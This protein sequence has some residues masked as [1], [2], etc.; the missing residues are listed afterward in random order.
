MGTSGGASDHSYIWL[1][2][3]RYYITNYDKLQAI[4]EEPTPGF[5]KTWGKETA[6]D[7]L[8]KRKDAFQS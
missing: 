6:M 8:F 7:F 5:L 4:N 3:S 2:Y 1:H